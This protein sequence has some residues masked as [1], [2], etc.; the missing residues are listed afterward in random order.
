[1]KKSLKGLFFCITGSLIVLFCSCT[2]TAQVIGEPAVEPAVVQVPQP[3]EE[4]AAIRE[5]P[6][7]KPA[8]A[9]SEPEPIVAKEQ[10]TS[11]LKASADQ[12][13]DESAVVAEIGEHTITRGDLE[14][15]VLAQLVG[16]RDEE[17][18]NVVEPSDV[19][20]VLM[21]MLAEKAMIMEGR[22][23]NLLEGDSWIKRYRNES[24]V[25]LLLQ[26]E[27]KDRVTVSDA[28][29]DATVKADPKLDRARAEAMIR[30][31]K[32]RAAVDRFYDELCKKLHLEKVRFNFPKVAQIHQRLLLEPQKERKEWWITHSQIE[33]ELTPQ[34]K[35]IV[36][37]KFDGGKVT[38]LDWFETLN[39]Y[40][41]PRR[42]KD[43]NTIEAV[44]RLLDATLRIPIFVREAQLRGLDKD[45]DYVKRVSEREERSLLGK[46]KRQAYDQVPDATKEEIRDYF[47]T[48]KEQFKTPDKLKI[49]QIWCADFNTALEARSELDSG[50]DLQTVRDKYSLRKERPVEVSAAR[51]GIFF[52][53]MWAGEPN[54]VIGPVKGMY[55]EG[56]GREADW[57]ARWRV[58]KILEK[59]P[60]KVREY[61]SNME[62]T[63][64]RRMRHARREIA[65]AKY[66][67]E[68]LGKYRYKIYA[69]RLRGID[70]LDIP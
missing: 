70:P 67:R 54:Q 4:P 65:L 15:R 45:E 66:E 13:L 39:E 10:R 9:P 25:R 47:E 49:E 51:E 27:L 48:H 63:V 16:D 55:R 6:K 12:V 61:A 53:A 7:Q 11:E 58:I 31:R 59:R 64:K 22:S 30:G 62:Y 37:A 52:D 20:T 40:S 69:D 14:Q 3:P 19:N 24:L 28:E 33:H 42:P 68:L 21:K 57:R 50:K 17:D 38:V 18:D 1:M 26:A 5:Q 41:P 60:G 35:E 56:K 34:Q 32:Q 43:L 29:I 36:L 23:K 44:E 8:V 46:V 2:K